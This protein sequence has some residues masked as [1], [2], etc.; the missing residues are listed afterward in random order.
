M[1]GRVIAFVPG[2]LAE[3]LRSPFSYYLLSN[4][5]KIPPVIDQFQGQRPEKRQ[6]IYHVSHFDSLFNSIFFLSFSY[7]LVLCR[8][9][10]KSDW[11]V[12]I[13]FYE[14]F[15]LFFPILIL[16]FNFEF[17]FLQNTTKSLKGYFLFF[18]FGILYKFFVNI[19]LQYFIYF[20]NIYFI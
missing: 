15:F 6:V 10:Y 11:C 2:T 16:S 5:C 12:Y 20:R 14:K 13:D 9:E 1:C 17:F 3:L 7:H 18:S 4:N 8:V 19:L